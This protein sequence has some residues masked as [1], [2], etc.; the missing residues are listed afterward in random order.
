VIERKTAALISAACTVGAILGDPTLERWQLESIQRAGL[1]LGSAYQM[2]DDL[3]DVF[4]DE[5]LGK[6]TWTDQRGG[7]LTW[8]YIRL[9]QQ[10]GDPGLREL[11]TQK[12]LNEGEKSHILERM[13]HYGIRAQFKQRAQRE[14]AEV[15]DLLHWMGDSDLRELLFDSFDFAVERRS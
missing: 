4:G 5:R 15:K 9:V 10:S 6:P 1:L 7:W 3:L 14:I 2:I 13:E 12:Q 8:P 11:L